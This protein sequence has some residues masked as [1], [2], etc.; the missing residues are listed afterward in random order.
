MSCH[1]CVPDMTTPYVG[2]TSQSREI[3]QGEVYRNQRLLL[4]PKRA[5]AENAPPK[6][7][8]Q[9]GDGANFP[10]IYDRLGLYHFYGTCHGDSASTT[11]GGKAQGVTSSLHG[12]NQRHNNSGACG[13]NRM[14]QAYS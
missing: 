10:F 3:T 13:S 7:Q 8:H 9:R 5:I 11:K 1:R 6:T 4:H 14:A 2:A 12:M